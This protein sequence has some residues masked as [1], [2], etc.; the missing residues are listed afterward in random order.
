MSSSTAS[1]PGRKSGPGL[2]KSRL[3]GTGGVVVGVAKIEGSGRP[4][5]GG[6]I[7][8]IP[9]TERM[10]LWLSAAKVETG[11][12]TAAGLG[13]EVGDEAFFEE[14]FAGETASE[15]MRNKT[16]SKATKA[17]NIGVPALDGNFR[18]AGKIRQLVGTRMPLSGIQ[19]FFHLPVLPLDASGV[20]LNVLKSGLTLGNPVLRHG[21]AP[22]N[23]ALSGISSYGTRTE[24]HC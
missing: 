24:E 20:A 11:A 5:S 3:A 2:G 4:D 1:P 16:S 22:E 14:F 15:G 9:S 10:S 13:V 18:E 19:A 21:L 23:A 7:G 8:P 6:A 12:G 17:G